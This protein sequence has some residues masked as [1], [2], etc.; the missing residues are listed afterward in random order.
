MCKSGMLT[1]TITCH[2]R[3]PIIHYKK[4]ESEKPVYFYP[5]HWGKN[6]KDVISFLFLKKK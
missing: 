2:C 6:K 5:S 1:V 3:R 4:K